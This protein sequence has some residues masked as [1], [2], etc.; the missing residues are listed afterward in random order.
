MLRFHQY[1]F[2]NKCIELLEEGHKNILFGAIPRS[3]KSYMMAG[4]IL[5]MVKNNT[6]GKNK[7][8]IMVTPAPN[9]TFD[10][11]KDIYDVFNNFENMNIYATVLKDNQNIELKADTNNVI[12]VSKQ[13]LGWT[14]MD[15]S[16]NGN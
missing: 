11:Y 14:K 2:I 12:I 7:N 13:R 3:G 1:L 10:E 6:S 8:F 5:E 16:G 4:T 15:E 9:E